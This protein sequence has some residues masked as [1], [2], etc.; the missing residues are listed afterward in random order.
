[1]A[2]LARLETSGITTLFSESLEM[3]Y[4]VKRG[5][6][7]IVGDCTSLMIFSEDH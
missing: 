7:T 3:P 6:L 2:A 4:Q 1:L 5:S